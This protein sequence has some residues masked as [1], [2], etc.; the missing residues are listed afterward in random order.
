MVDSSKGQEWTPEEQRLLSFWGEGCSIRTFC[1]LTGL[2]KYR[3]A[4]LLEKAGLA[5][6]FELTPEKEAEVVRLKTEDPYMKHRE[7]A[8]R[9]G[10]KKD[11]VAKVVASNGLTPPKY[12]KGKWTRISRVTDETKALVAEAWKKSATPSVAAI[13]KEL[14]LGK[15]TVRRTLSEMG[16]APEAKRITAE[17]EALVLEARKTSPTMTLDEIASTVN[18]HM[19]SVKK[20]IRKHGAYLTPEQVQVN[21]R[22]G[23]RPGYME[24]ARKHLTEGVVLARS[25][26]IRETYISWPSW[27]RKAKGQTTKDWWASLTPDEYH[28]Y[29]ENRRAALEGSEATYS[30]L[31]RNTKGKSFEDYCSDVATEKGG[32]FVGPY[33]GSKV[34][35]QW[36][37]K[38]GHL[39]HAIPNAVLASGSW[40]PSCFTSSAGENEMADYIES[41]HGEGILRGS[42]SVIAPRELDV[43]VPQLK[44]GFE[45]DGLFWHSH[46]N[47]KNKD[48]HAQKMKMARRAGIRLFAFFEDEWR[49]K[50]ELVK[51]MIA[52]RLGGFSGEKLNA[53]QLDYK[54]VSVAEA[55]AFFDVNHLSGGTKAKKAVGLYHEGRLVA[56]ASFRTNF[57]REFELARL[58]THRDYL[59]RGGAGKLLSKV[60]RPLVSFSDNRVG[61]GDVYRKLGFRLLQ[62]NGPSYWYTD[63]QVRIWRWRC[64][65][66]ND[67]EI[68]AEYPTEELQCRAGIQSMKIFGDNRPL[69]KIEDYGHRKWVLDKKPLT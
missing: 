61:D 55:N 68:L 66:I 19:D 12:R 39:F 56:C 43:Y 23:Q 44:V 16:V 53:R 15:T 5:P 4:K 46:Y 69:Y 62:E 27:K 57:N 67:P 17:Q 29:M 28:S 38:K 11:I 14:G 50:N 41:I 35:T 47:E 64:R 32:R 20:I 18:L 59:V 24:R 22:A 48:K 34:K 6:N 31:H 58:A 30:Y 51:S 21:A 33:M 8:E 63:G 36:K 3:A 42:R 13:A 2:S 10:L 25:N 60:N 45:Y 52:Q 1:Q 9:V 49:D 65:R 37:C 7:I 26:K 54:E 40:C